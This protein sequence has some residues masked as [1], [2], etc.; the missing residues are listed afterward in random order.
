MAKVTERFE[1]RYEVG[2]LEMGT[3]YRWC[4]ENVLV[5]CECGESTRLTASDTA[6]GACDEDHAAIIFEALGPR[7][8]DQRDYHPWR[9]VPSSSSYYAPVRGT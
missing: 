1:A 7:P 5:E 3:V 9:S 8:E 2:H 6:C 4:P